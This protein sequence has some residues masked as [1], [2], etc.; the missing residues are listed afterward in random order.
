MGCRE[1]YTGKKLRIVPFYLKIHIAA[2]D[3]VKCHEIDKK[4]TIE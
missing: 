1:L 4:V 2:D 3:F